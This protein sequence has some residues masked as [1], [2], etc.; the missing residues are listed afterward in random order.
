MLAK[1]QGRYYTYFQKYR[2]TP[3]G[4]YHLY[5]GH[6]KR[7]GIMMKLSFTQ[8][9]EIISQPCRY[10]GDHGPQIGVDRVDNAVGYT[11]ENSVACCKYCNFMKKDMSEEDFLEHVIKISTFTLLNR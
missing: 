2:M 11:L 1:K 7:R 10:C 3:K 5:N 9:S 8:F 4:K 6:A